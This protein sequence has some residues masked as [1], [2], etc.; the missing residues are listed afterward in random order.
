MT[1]SHA[2]ALNSTGKAKLAVMAL[3]GAHNRFTDNIDILS[4][5]AAFHRDTGNLDAAR[6]YADKLRTI[7]P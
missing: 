6:I 5:L 1:R 4:A 3:Q 7:S 2:V